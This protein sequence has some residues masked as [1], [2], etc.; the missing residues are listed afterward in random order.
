MNHQKIKWIIC[1]SIDQLTKIDLI[2]AFL[3]SFSVF[4][5]LLVLP[6]YAQNLDTITAENAELQREVKRSIK[7]QDIQQVSSKT[8]AG[9][10]LIEI[11]K[12][13]QYAEVQVLD[14]KYDPQNQQVQLQLQGEI[15]NLIA[16]TNDL[17]QY[18]NIQLLSLSLVQDDP[19]KQPNLNIIWQ[20]QEQT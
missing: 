19:K 5:Y 9:T 15:G 4:S 10:A 14:A 8:L 13:Y 7:Q 3:C 16:S 11:A 2:I 1:Q 20:V 18:Q 6:Q 12:S 17:K